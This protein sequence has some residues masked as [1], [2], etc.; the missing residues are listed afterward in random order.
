MI[1]MLELDILYINSKFN[2]EE[3]Y[4]EFMWFSNIFMFT[5]VM[6]LYFLLCFFFYCISEK[7]N[8]FLYIT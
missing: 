5:T 1:N 8:I 7:N 3:E 6:I 4:I 2:K